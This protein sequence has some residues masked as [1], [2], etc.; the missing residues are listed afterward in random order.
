MM[1]Q[2]SLN[3]GGGNG[4]ES[5]AKGHGQVLLQFALWLGVS[6]F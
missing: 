3:V 4:V 2:T 1:G 6:A 5:F